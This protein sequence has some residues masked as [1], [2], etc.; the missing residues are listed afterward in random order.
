[1][2]QLPKACNHKDEE[3][4]FI[5][6]YRDLRNKSVQDKFI[7]VLA[8]SHPV[9]AQIEKESSVD[10]WVY[11]LGAQF[12]FEKYNETI[13]PDHLEAIWA[14]NLSAG[15]IDYDGETKITADEQAIIRAFL[16]DPI[17]DLTMEML[18]V[19][20]EGVGWRPGMA[21]QNKTLPPRQQMIDFQ[22]YYYIHRRESG[23]LENVLHLV[24]SDQNGNSVFDWRMLFELETAISNELNNK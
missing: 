17:V 20:I 22:E 8:K 11:E 19:M 21:A 13:D 3:I 1:M 6:D 10:D 14:E 12:W 24:G 2:L 16:K 9:I 15:T 5:F 7:K 4:V 23:A 18:Y